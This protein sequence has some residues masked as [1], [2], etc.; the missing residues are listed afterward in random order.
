MMKNAYGHD[1]Y[2]DRHKKTLHSARVI[3]SIVL[4]CLPPVHSAID[5]GCGVGTWLSVLKEKGAIEIQGIDG[6][7]V[8]QNLLEIPKQNFRDVDFEQAILSDKKYDLSISLEVAEHISQENAPR[9]VESL[10]EASDFVLFSAA[11]P[12]QGG[13]HHINEQWP[14]YWAEI[15]ANKGYVAL[16]FVRKQIWNDKDIPVWYRQNI[17]LYVNKE[18]LHDVQ[19]PESDKHNNS[20]ISIIHPEMYLSKIKSASNFRC[21][22]GLF[23]KTLLNRIK[24]KLSYRY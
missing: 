8:D 10:V 13:N 22:L 23:T 17:I 4:D 3:L 16:D 7:W 20:V 14:D 15:F 1:F 12:L 11:I 24:K 9:F 19:I 21:D 5:F 18:K 6:P 2:K